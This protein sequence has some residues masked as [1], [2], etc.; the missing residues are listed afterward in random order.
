MK[1]LN[2]L[3]VF[4]PF[5]EINKRMVGCYIGSMLAHINSLDSSQVMPAVTYANADIQKL[6]ILRENKINLYRWVNKI[7]GKNL[8]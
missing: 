3:S 5:T 4:I 8:C 6:D 7:N 1:K 2:F